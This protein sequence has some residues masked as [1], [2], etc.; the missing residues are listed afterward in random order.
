MSLSSRI[1]GKAKLFSDLEGMPKSGLTSPKMR[2]ELFE[3][4]TPDSAW[5]SEL[6][7]LGSLPWQGNEERRV[8][9]RILT[10]EFREYV[11]KQKPY[12]QVRHGS[13]LIGTLVIE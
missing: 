11:L 12:L 9:V 6:S 4:N 7:V 1:F 8:E 2:V 13:Q 5:I 10:D 3:E